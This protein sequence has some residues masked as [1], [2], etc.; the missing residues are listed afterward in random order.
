MLVVDVSQLRRLLDR[1]QIPKETAQPLYPHRLSVKGERQ[2]GGDGEE[3]AEG[4]DLGREEFTE[5]SQSLVAIVVLVV[6]VLCKQLSVWTDRGKRVFTR[7]VRKYWKASQ[8]Q[9]VVRGKMMCDKGGHSP[10]SW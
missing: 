2:T 3:A 4:E 1:R 5:V 10:M 9:A 6:L 8:C 7:T